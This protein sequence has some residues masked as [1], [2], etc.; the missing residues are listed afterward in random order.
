MIVCK[1]K[2]KVKLKKKYGK[3]F[4]KNT[5]EGGTHKL[6]KL[7]STSISIAPLLDKENVI[8]RKN[9]ICNGNKRIEKYRIKHLKT[10]DKSIY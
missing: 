7:R 10:S 3:Q 5:V 1:T 6:K 9:R 8:L 4:T 2:D